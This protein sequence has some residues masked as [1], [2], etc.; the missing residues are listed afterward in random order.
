MDC[1]ICNHTGKSPF[2]AGFCSQCNGT[3]RL[4]DDRLR[5]PV[6]SNC[7]GT[8]FSPFQAGVCE[9]C[10]GW[11]RLPHPQSPTKTPSPASQQ[12]SSPTKTMK[13]FVSHADADKS[14]VTKFVDLLQL[15]IGVNHTDIFYSSQKGSVPNGDFF[16]QN[17]IS[18]LN[19][20]DFV[21][22][23]LSRSYFASHFC[24]AEAGA[25]LSRKAAATCQFFSLVIPPARFSD[26]QGML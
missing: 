5:N 19:T 17:I 23:L 7:A 9:I 20:S 12:I 24:L 8:G 14:L 18:E 3:G 6:C 4:S 1:P 11:G 2:S 22:A 13:I 10:D 25:A 26:L 21:I 16:V 15:G